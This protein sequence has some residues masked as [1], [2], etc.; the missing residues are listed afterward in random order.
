[1]EGTASMASECVYITEGLTLQAHV[2][3]NEKELQ[4]L[5]DG[6]L[7]ADVHDN[8]KLLYRSLEKAVMILV[9]ASNLG[10]GADLLL[11]TEYLRTIHQSVMNHSSTR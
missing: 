6:R 4:E 1:M 5:I 8:D 3:K 9:L 2:N 7:Q 10:F 11:V